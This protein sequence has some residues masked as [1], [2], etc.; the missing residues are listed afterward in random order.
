M[1]TAADSLVSTSVT[2]VYSNKR[3]KENNE[4][5]VLAVTP[6]HPTISFCADSAVVDL[7]TRGAAKA[8][9]ER[10]A[11]SKT[12]LKPRL[13]RY[14]SATYNWVVNHGLCV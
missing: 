9:P 1:V 6:T 11:N 5:T 7:P 10:K 12:V 3:K 2:T 8:E 14:T 13:P 4:P